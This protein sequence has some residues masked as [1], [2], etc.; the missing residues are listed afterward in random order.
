MLGDKEIKEI[1]KFLEQEET[2]GYFEKRRQRKLKKEIYDELEALELERVNLY[3]AKIRNEI[4]KTRK[5]IKKTN[6]DTINHSAKDEEFE[7]I[8]E[9]EPNERKQETFVPRS[10]RFFR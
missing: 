5:E 8:P 9:I 3:K 7:N 2:G 1:Q 10:T 4:N 6:V